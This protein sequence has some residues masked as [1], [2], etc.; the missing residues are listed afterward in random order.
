MGDWPGLRGDRSVRSPGRRSERAS[1]SNGAAGWRQAL[2]EP[3]RARWVRDRPNAHWYAVAAVCL[4]AFMGQLDASIVTLALPSLHRDFN[5]G[6]GAVTWV[7][8][9]YLIVLVALVVPVGRLADMAGR[10]LLYTYGFVVFV[11][12]S[13]LCGLAPTLGSLV[14]FRVLQAIGAAMLQANSVAIIA[15]AIPKERLG[16]AIGVQ[17]AAQALG[18]A[19]GPSLGGLLIALGG[20]RLIF[21]V[22]IPA[23]IVGAMLGWLFIPRSRELQRR[24]RFDWTGLGLFVPA[25]AALLVVVSFGNELGWTSSLTVG[26]LGS[27]IGLA[28]AFVVHERRA[29]APMVDAALFRRLRFSA[30]IG[31]GLL[32]YLVLFGTLFVVPFFF[33]RALGMGVGTAGLELTV[34]AVV[35]GLV[36]PFAG[37][38]ADRWGARS[39]TVA[40]MLLVATSLAVLGL[41]QPGTAGRLGA[42]AVLGAGL[43]LFT[44]PNNAAVMATAPRSQAGMASGIL[45]MTRGLGTAMGLAFTSL[46]FGI[47][48]GSNQLSPTAVTQGFEA[49]TL[50]LAGVAIVAAGLAA[51]GGRGSNVGRPGPAGSRLLQ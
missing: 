34:M 29:S 9:S 12:G 41:V 18:L 51:L 46:V 40:G 45:N 28:A 32:S 39:L 27:F 25:V 3:R 43:G 44:P 8:L 13:A 50:F 36:A 22:N 4:G 6:L 30:A 20:W 49:A 23:G 24:V 14:G 16:R 11:V 7:G 19:L 10:K 26:L 42:L 15:L 31:A 35:L 37:H 48:A 38:V 17:G 1:P 21:F 5:A 47:I 2:V 33:E